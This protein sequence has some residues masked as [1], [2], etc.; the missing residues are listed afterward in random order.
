MF[1]DSS[2][3]EAEFK[4]YGCNFK[5][6]QLLHQTSFL[7][8][9]LMAVNFPGNSVNE[10]MMSPTSSQTADSHGLIDIDVIIGM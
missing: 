4:I 10:V 8:L 9:L 7:L 2:T 5:R 6:S 3:N 1:I